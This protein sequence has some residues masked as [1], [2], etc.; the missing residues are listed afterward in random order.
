[1]IYVQ[2]QQYESAIYIIRSDLAVKK[3]ATLV[4]NCTWNL[5][6]KNERALWN[7][8]HAFSFARGGPVPSRSHLKFSSCEIS[9]PHGLSNRSTSVNNTISRFKLFNS[10]KFQEF[11][12]ILWKPLACHSS[13]MVIPWKWSTCCSL[14]HSVTHWRR[15]WR[16][17][18]HP[19]R[20]EWW[21]FS[22]WSLLPK[23]WWVP[24]GGVWTEDTF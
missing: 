16:A 12:F 11:Y 8:G 6:G 7:C 15:E 4:T 19:W 17:S 3:E 20:T 18:L 5:E 10:L 1:M 14:N 9:H 2:H 24:K 22:I 13:F 21:L 23:Y